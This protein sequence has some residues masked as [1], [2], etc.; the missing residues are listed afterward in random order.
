MLIERTSQD[1]FRKT[2]VSTFG[3][4]DGR[5]RAGHRNG[6]QYFWV[7]HLASGGKDI[8]G[9]ETEELISG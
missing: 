9:E 3:F 8:K 1:N 2:D 6:K 5:G 7:I 4:D